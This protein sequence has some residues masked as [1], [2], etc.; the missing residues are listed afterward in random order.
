MDGKTN[1]V[2]RLATL[3][4]DLGLAGQVITADALHTQRET[5]ELIVTGKNAHYILVVKKNQPGLPG[6]GTCPG[7]TSRPAT[8]SAAGDTA[9]RSAG[10]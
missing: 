7:R 5:A 1:E 10:T 8:A 9:A 4:A 6:S 2:T 3:L